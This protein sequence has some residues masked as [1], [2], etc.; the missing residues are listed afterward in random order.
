[1]HGPADVLDLLGLLHKFLAGPAG[2]ELKLDQHVAVI[3]ANDTGA[4]CESA[5][6]DSDAL[7]ARISRKC[8]GHRR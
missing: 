7:R 6:D 5:I 2:L 4:R 3:L 8:D 1:M